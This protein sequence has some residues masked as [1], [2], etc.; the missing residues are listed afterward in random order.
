MKVSK[1]NQSLVDLAGSFGLQATFHRAFDQVDDPFEALDQLIQMGFDRLLTSGLKDKAIDGLELI[2]A[3]HQR[4][5]VENSNY[6]GQWC[7]SGECP[8]TVEDRN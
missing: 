2:S 4:I 6:G 7:E 1:K 8:V 3:M 5:W